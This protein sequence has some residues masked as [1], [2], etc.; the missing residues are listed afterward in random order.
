MNIDKLTEIAEW[1]EAGAPERKGV[2][3]FDMTGYIEDASETPGC[4]TACCIAGAAVQFDRDE[5]FKNNWDFITGRDESTANFDHYAGDILGLDHE[6][7]GALFFGR[8]VD[9]DE[10]TPAWAARCIRHLIAT[11]EVDWDGTY[12]P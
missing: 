9:L 12:E 10:I 7:R 8:G 5:P 4:G 11:G 1:L 6:Q 2:T 3:R